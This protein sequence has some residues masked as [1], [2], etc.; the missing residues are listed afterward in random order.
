MSFKAISDRFFGRRKGRPLTKQ[1]QFLFDKA[2]APIRLDD[3]EQLFDQIDQHAKNFKKSVLEIG[4]GH[5]EHIHWRAAN[6]PDTLWVG[7][8]LFENGIAHLLSLIDADPIHNNLLIYTEHARRL[9]K[10]LPANYLDEAYLLFA[11]PWPKKRHATRR[12]LSQDNL[13]LFLNALKP[14][15]KLKIASDDPTLIEWVDEQIALFGKFKVTL[16]CW[17]DD[18][19]GVPITKYEQKAIREGRTPKFWILEKP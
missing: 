19:T 16:H 2:L 1:K 7:C 15:G 8:E 4:F 5:G 11:D 10:Q 14:G 18:E 6:T 12:F 13:S 17:R 3:N 9:L